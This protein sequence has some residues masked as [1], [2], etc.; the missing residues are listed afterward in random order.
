MFDLD[1]WQEIFATIAKNKLRTFLTAFS[2]AWGIFMLVILLGA[3]N[4]LQNGVTNMFKDDAINSIWISSGTTS[5]PHKGLQPGRRVQFTNEDYDAIRTQVEGID[6][7]SA[8]FHIRSS[9]MVNYKDEFG[10]FSIRCIHPDSKYLEKTLIVE[11]RYINDIDIA[12]YRKVVAI[13]IRVKDALFAHEPAIGKYINLNG[14]AFKVVGVFEDEGNEGETE[15]MYIPITTAQR[16]FNGANNIN[17]L[18][19]TVGDADLEESMKISAQINQTLSKRNNYSTEDPKA[20]SI[21]NSIERFQNIMGVLGGIQAFIW[22]IGIGT[23]LA[24]VVGVGNIMM[25]VVKE[26]TKEIGIRKAIGATPGS[27]LSLIIQESV[28]ITSMA[29]YLGLML[30]VGLLALV[31][32]V[33]PPDTPMFSNPEINLGVALQA[34]ILLVVAGT[35][36]GLVPAIKAARIRPIEALRDE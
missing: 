12:E 18:M 11:G 20:V 1:K 29:G 6:H 2:V 27:I 4:G 7:I 32:S 28:F 19:V 17:Q 34:T 24:G 8:R 26:R 9:V 23:I 21:H 14:I 35:M 5:L 22:V 13:G 30:G 10:A 33:V 16:I 31:A 25:I 15:T 3:G 36:A